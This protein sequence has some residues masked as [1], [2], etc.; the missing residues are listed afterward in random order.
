MEA[1]LHGRGEAL[2][3]RATTA[4]GIFMDCRTSANPS[5]ISRWAPLFL[6]W[7]WTGKNRHDQSCGTDIRH[8]VGAST[9]KPVTVPVEGGFVQGAGC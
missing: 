1:A 7:R 3:P 6:R 5:T 9:T 2:V 8:D 4:A